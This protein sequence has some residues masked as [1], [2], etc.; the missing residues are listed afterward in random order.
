MGKKILFF[1]IDGTL[2]NWKN[3]I[4]DSTKAAVRF[5]REAG[6][7]VF[8]NSGRTRGFIYNE[9]LLGIGFDGIVSGCGT[10]IEYDGEVI[11]DSE[12]DPETATEIVEGV[13]RY[14]CR[15]VLEGK[16][17]LYLDHDEFADDWYGQ[18][19]MRE[20]GPRLKGIA[21]NWGKWEIQ[22]LS[23]N[24]QD[25][26]I[27]G[28][29]KEYGDRFDFIKH[30]LPVCELV[31]K[32]FSKGTGVEKVCELLGADIKDTYAFGDSMNDREMLIKAGTSIVMDSGSD[33]AKALADYVTA[34]QEEDGIW[35]A[36]KHFGLI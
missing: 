6:H 29:I 1:D 13:R 31:P 17:Y 3:E 28:C 22:K 33:N 19:L 11:Y 14:G 2:W 7:L 12:I 18:K 9:D 26:D 25:S 20:L 16:H 10:M 4:P 34:G 27:D 21:E 32:G 35:H 5:A 23:C 8:I 24:T 15:P 36:C 30:D